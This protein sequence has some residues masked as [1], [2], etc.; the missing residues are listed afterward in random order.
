M[1]KEYFLG[2]DIGT[3]S[4]GY[5]VTDTDYSIKKFNGKSMWGVQVFEE[6][7]QAA[8]R[9]GFRSARRRLDR[10]QQRITLLKELM[11]SEISKADV[12]FLKRISESALYSNDKETKSAFSFF[13]DNSYTDIEYNKDFPTIHHLII[14]LMEW[15]KKYDIRLVYLACSYILSHRGHFLNTADKNN[16]E[17]V[18]DFEVVYNDLLNWFINLEVDVPWSC[19]TIK[20][21]EILKKKLPV[22]KKEKE[23]FDLL[24][25]GKKPVAKENYIISK[26]DLIKLLC[27]GK[28]TLSKLFRNDEYKELETDSICLNDSEFEDK[29]E[30]ISVSLRD[31]DIELLREIKKVFDWSLLSDLLGERKENEAL[32][33]SNS[34]VKIYEKHKEDLALLK[35]IIKKYL[36][37]K[38]IEVFKTADSS[39]KNNKRIVPNYVAYSGNIKSLAVGTAFDLE[40]CNIDEFSDY[41]LNIVKDISLDEKDKQIF[42]NMVTRLKERKKKRSC[43][44]K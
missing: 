11:A 2:L 37:N 25:D 9:R 26:A 13:T 16:I 5:A 19:N 7:K 10:R 44:N 22:S 32:S 40:K 12:D 17:N 29:I 18:L 33:I 6:G 42:D 38:Y 31:G 3:N 1:E 14:A 27:G 4:L 30:N 39:K 34:K 20:F 15:N 24:F 28:T 23:F 36:P 8:E 21:S 43:Q 35:I 41:I